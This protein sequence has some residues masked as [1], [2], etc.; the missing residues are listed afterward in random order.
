[1]TGA[2]VVPLFCRTDDHARYQ[3]EFLP[4]YHVPSSIQDGD[5]ATPWVQAAL[6]ALEDR[7]RLHPASSN[8]YFFWNDLEPP[9][10]LGVTAPSPLRSRRRER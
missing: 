5:E 9:R 8:D 3:L 7:V 6:H 2:P 1:M 4:G 10:I